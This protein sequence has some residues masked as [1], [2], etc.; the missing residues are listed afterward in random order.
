MINVL[1]QLGVFP[2]SIETAAY[3]NLKRVTDYRWGKVDRVTK[4]P[5]KQFTG[6]GDD[7]I[8]LDGVVY[9]NWKGGVLQVSLLRELAGTGKPQRMVAMPSMGLG[10][11]HGLWVIERVEE[12]QSKIGAWG[13]PAKQRFRIRLSAYGEDS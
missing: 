5:S 7:V 12:E 10:V 4:T 11:D 8:D 6:L 13:V 2:F 9:P 1:M 3:Q